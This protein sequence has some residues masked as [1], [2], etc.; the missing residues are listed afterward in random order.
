M[1]FIPLIQAKIKQLPKAYL[2]QSQVLLNLQE[3]SIY[4]IK[5]L[6]HKILKE[7]SHII[8]FI[9]HFFIL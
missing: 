6:F 9:F 7:L 4:K 1:E 3:E 5:K 2:L 8:L